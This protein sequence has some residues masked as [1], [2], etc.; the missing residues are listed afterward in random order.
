[1][2]WVAVA[3]GGATLA[4]AYLN[5]QA[6]GN[7][8]DAQI[9]ASREATAAQLQMFNQQRADNEPWRQAGVGALKEMQNPEF[10]KNFTMADFKA[11]PGY[12]FRLNE[13]MK[14]IERS[15]AARGG[16]NSGATLKSLTQF[17]S[18][19]ASSEI[20]NAYTRFNADS[21]RRF[22]RLASLAGVGQ[23][24]NSQNNSAGQNYAN[25]VGQNAM[26]AGNANAAATMA[27]SNGYNN[28]IGQ[29]INSWM[30]YQMMNRLAPVK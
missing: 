8:A 13:G 30:Q 22:N 10:Q 17:N 25:Q 21:D 18:D 20:G 24:A 9:G 29:G 1:M 12:Q 2:S 23:T 19:T 27:T 6:A 16:M 3:V 11:D 7:A 4:G 15:A 5:S 26:S 14:A 28:A